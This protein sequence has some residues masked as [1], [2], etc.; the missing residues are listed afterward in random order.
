MTEGQKDRRKECQKFEARCF[1]SDSLH[2][3][4]IQQ[5]INFN[6]DETIKRKTE[7]KSPFA[8]EVKQKYK[9]KNEYNR[10][11]RPL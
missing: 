2:L 11:Q 9:Q 7:R 10:K 1:Y 3:Y 4:F 5:T 8:W 6:E